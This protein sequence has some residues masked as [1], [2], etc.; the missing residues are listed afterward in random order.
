MAVEAPGPFLQGPGV[1]REENLKIS[2]QV[3][4]RHAVG[5]ADRARL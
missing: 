3:E 2:H 4:A 1:T 5:P